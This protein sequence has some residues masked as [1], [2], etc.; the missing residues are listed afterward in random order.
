[1]SFVLVQNGE[2][3]LAKG[4]GYVDLRMGS[5]ISTE[6]T[7]VRLGPVSKLFLITAVMQLVEQG[8]LDLH[9]D[10]N[11]YLT[12]LQLDNTFPEP[13]TPATC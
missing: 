3:V 12:A 13:M 1:V 10:I 4:Y 6:A 2:I 9:A 11:R 5:T 7:V 8:K